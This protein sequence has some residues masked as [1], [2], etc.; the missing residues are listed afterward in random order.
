[1]R[2]GRA[3]A[4]AA[5]TDGR[6]RT[7]IPAHRTFRGSPGGTVPGR[8]QPSTGSRPAR[9]STRWLPANPVAPVMSVVRTALFPRAG[10]QPGPDVQ[11]V[12]IDGARSHVDRVG[13]EARVPNGPAGA[14]RTT[15]AGAAGD[16]NV[17]ARTSC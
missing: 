10:V 1:M 11:A 4:I 7:S 15:G 13:G 9:R 14:S 17:H 12:A 8:C 6:S 16:R 5:I 2:A 3:S